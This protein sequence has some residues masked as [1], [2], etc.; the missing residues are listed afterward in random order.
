MRSFLF[1]PRLAVSG[2]RRN[3]ILYVPYLLGGFPDGDALLYSLLHDLDCRQFGHKGG[4][5]MSVLLML[6][7]VV[8][9]LLTVLI[10]FYLNGYVIKQR[11]REFGLYSVLGL[12]KGN[13]C[14]LLFWEILFSCIGSLICGILAG[15]VFS[16]LMY[17]LLL[18][19]TRLPV[20]L[21]I[22]VPMGAVN[23][24][25]YLFLAAWGIVLLRNVIR[26]FR[27]DPI[28][29]LRAPP[30]VSRSPGPAGSWR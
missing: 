13:L 10:L 14:L 25:V 6:S 26:I 17:L 21:E 12:G 16:Q 28:E 30:R 18:N 11:S 20:D 23:I 29:I 4:S 2:M 1:Y 27:S 9:G 24:T 3:K 5:S 19:I 15:A 7:S 22:W 8:C